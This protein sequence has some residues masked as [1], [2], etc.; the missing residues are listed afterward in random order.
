[1]TQTTTLPLVKIISTGGT[2]ANTVEGRVPFERIIQDVP[3]AS[4]YA[5]FE[6]EEVT[7]VGGGSVG[8]TEWLQV[9]QAVNRALRSQPE[10]A[11]VLVTH[12]TFTSEETAFFLN[13]TVRSDKPV[14]VVCSQRAHGL[15]GNDGDWNFVCA[16]RVVTNPE[17]HGQGVL[18]VMDE[19]IL[20]AR[21]VLKASGRWDGFKTRYLGP[22]GHVDKDRV[23]FYR[24][25]R[26]RHTH[27]SEFDVDGLTELPRVDVIYTYPGADAVPIR[28]CV[29][30]G[31][32]QGLVVAGFTFSGTP[33]AGQRPALKA[34]IEQ[35]VP[36]VL[37]GRGGE[38]RLA[39]PQED[40]EPPYL[41]APDDFLYVYGDNLSPQK[42]RILLMLGLT[43]THDRGELQRIFDE[44]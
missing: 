4:R 6:V 26:R 7:R 2:I 14:A 21:D 42:A 40:A 10:I 31:G 8:P 30:Q 27:Q 28:A 16:T 35:G 22:L 34:A 43:R 29:E 5:R 38:H 1:M 23:T 33:A 15:P 3:L 25:I 37:T 18:V 24:S 44:Y 19:T 13:L 12:G 39:V 36:V 20:P 17:A 32:A 11:G 41:P 9:A